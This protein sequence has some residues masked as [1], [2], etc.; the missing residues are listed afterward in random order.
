MAEERNG[1]AAS[2]EQRAPRSA[3]A[4]QKP[5]RP[6]SMMHSQ[7]QTRKTRGRLGREVLGKLGKTLEAYYDEVRK[8]GVPDR[9]KMLLDQFDERTVNKDK[10]PG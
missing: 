9:F 3:F 4:E 1:S 8:E 10:E 6:D 2:G 5:P 7:T